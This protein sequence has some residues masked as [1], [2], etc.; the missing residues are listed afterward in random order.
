LP[1][2]GVFESTSLKP[3]EVKLTEQLI[4]SLTEPFKPKQYHN[5]FQE[6]LKK[7]IAAKQHGKSVALGEQPAK[8]APV[9]DMMT[10]L[11]KSLAASSLRSDERQSRKSKTRKVAAAAQKAS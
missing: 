6:Q 4:E 8:R 2:Y 7:L 1:E 9:I 5:E 11:K 3:Q 10:A